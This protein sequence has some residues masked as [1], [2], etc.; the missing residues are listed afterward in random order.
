MISD[1][2]YKKLCEQ[3]S[4]GILILNP[5]FNI[6]VMNSAAAELFDVDA[7]SLTGKPV[8]M[9]VSSNR[10]DVIHRLIKRAM[11]GK[12][13]AEYHLRRGEGKNIRF[14]SIMIDPI[15]IDGH[16]EGICFWL[17]DMTRRMEMVHRIAEI[18]KL[19][20]LG[21]LAGGLAHH[22]NN[23]LGGIVTA[24]DHAISIKDPIIAQRTLTMIQD[25][26]NKASA[27]TRRLL[28]YSN[29]DLPDRDLAD[30]TEVVLNF[31]E[32]VEPLLEKSGWKIEVDVRG[33]P[34]FAVYP[35]KLRQILDALL[36]N[37]IQATGSE[38][39][40]I[41]ITMYEADGKVFLEFQDNGPGVPAQVIDRIFEPFFTTRGVLGGGSEGNLGLGLTVAHRL[42]E[43]LGGNLVYDI[44]KSKNGACFILSFDI[45]NSTR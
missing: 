28:D 17:R 38:G 14:L 45:P 8:E 41:H 27:L 1:E 36:A 25:G 18:E 32:E 29:P 9:L 11:T 23:I 12:H 15:R 44:E 37:S 35:K 2:F 42:A 16:L 39:G 4:I 19:A 24:V 3:A 31:V 21:K 40:K 6:E 10:R 43:D 20:S 34:I 13:S 5:E 26:L 33:V 22:F 30:L 7:S